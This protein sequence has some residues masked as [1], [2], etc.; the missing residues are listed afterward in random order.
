MSKALSN[1]IDLNLV[2]SHLI[3]LQRSQRPAPSLQHV[4]AD[5]L[6]TA[7]QGMHSPPSN[8]PEM[9]V[10][11]TNLDYSWT[12]FDQDTLPLAN[13]SWLLQDLMQEPKAAVPIAQPGTAYPS[14]LVGGSQTFQTRQWVGEQTNT[15]PSTLYRLFGHDDAAQ[16]E[17]TTLER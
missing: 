15:W 7:L 8:G 4:L 2:Q 1:D 17:N 10:P 5:R 13:P 14:G 9:M 16:A 3:S 11:D 12:I 6:E